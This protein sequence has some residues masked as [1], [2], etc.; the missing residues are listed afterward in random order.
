MKLNQAKKFYKKS[1]NDGLENINPLEIFKKINYELVRALQVVSEKIE[2]KEI[3]EVRQKNFTK[4][5]TIIYTLQTNLDFEKELK[6]STDLFKFYEF[7]RKKLI[8]GITGLKSKEILKSAVNLDKMFNFNYIQINGIN[9][10][11]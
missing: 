11:I 6:L 2:K 7:C 5:L 4:A 8:E 3:D 1:Q 10:V 9:N